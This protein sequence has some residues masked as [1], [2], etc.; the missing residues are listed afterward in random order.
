MEKE[1]VNVLL[2]VDM[3][4]DFIDGALGSEEAK[5]IV[6]GVAERIRSFDGMIILTK[7]CHDENYAQTI[8]GLS[9][10]EHCIAGTPG[11][12]IH[13]DID[14]AHREKLRQGKVRFSVAPK[15]T[16]GCTY[17]DRIL[18][19]FNIES[20][21][22]VGL[23]TDVCVISNALILRSQF[24]NIPIIVRSDLCAG[25]SP[26]RHKAALDIMFNCCIQVL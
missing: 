20:F 15:T 25:S 1:K 14:A 6:P 9:C 2:V 12:D 5:A 7:D 17:L 13:P 24:P 16:P 21:E 26:E 3:Q 19:S 11:W 8:E 10:P 4:N 23:C 18:E 22:I